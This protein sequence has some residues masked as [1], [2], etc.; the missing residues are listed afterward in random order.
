MRIRAGFS[1]LSAAIALAVLLVVT[2]PQAA[3]AGSPLEA[4]AAAA[5]SEFRV[6]V[7][8]LLALSYAETGWVDHGAAPSF[9]N[10]FGVVHLQDNPFNDG[11]RRAAALLGLNPDQ[12]KGNVRNNFRGAAALLR[13]NY[14]V[15]FPD[16][17]GMH[18]ASDLGR[19]Y[20]PVASYLQSGSAL[21]ERG[22]ADTVFEWVRRGASKMTPQG[23]IVLGANPNVTPQRGYLEAVPND[24]QRAL[25]DRGQRPP[26][27]S[28]V[29]DGLKL[30]RP[31]AD[32]GSGD[33]GAQATR[34]SPNR[35]LGRRRALI[36]VVV[37]TCQTGDT[38][39]HF[40][41][42]C[43]APLTDPYN[44]RGPVSAHYAVRSTDGWRVQLVHDRD[45]AWHAGT[46]YHNTLSV[47]IEHQGHSATGWFP[48]VLYRSSSWLTAWRCYLYWFGCDRAHVVGHDQL[49][50]GAPDPGPYW[51]W[52]RYMTCVNERMNYLNS[53]VPPTYCP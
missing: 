27:K 51:D 36:E 23:A 26:A 52:N 8:V 49:G 22:Y 4:A 14:R 19:W 48:D 17:G 16:D 46:D 50:V 38:A 6:P 45:T 24:W 13:E 40:E 3:E 47:G 39:Q 21:A 43:L 30:A 44:P 42:G 7:N 12:I 11:L 31:A 20:V 10:G 41:N 5:A 28:T 37:H 35:E 33:P 15:T 9:A 2:S 18:G 25:A 34:W 29:A 53:M 32:S 1:R